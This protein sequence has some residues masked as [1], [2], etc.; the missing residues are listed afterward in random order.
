M[1]RIKKVDALLLQMLGRHLVCHKCQTAPIALVL[2]SHN[3]L[4]LV[5][6]T[7]VPSKNSICEEDWDPMVNYIKNHHDVNNEVEC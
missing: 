4:M 3:H 6:Q 5:V 2:G 1:K 7:C